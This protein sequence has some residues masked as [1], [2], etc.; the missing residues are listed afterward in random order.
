[1]SEQS[2]ARSSNDAAKAFYG[3]SEAAFAE[4]I[5]QLGAVDP[6]LI[7]AFERTRE[8]F[9]KNTSRFQ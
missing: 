6:R 2:M 9:L 3:Q 7:K 8:T 1:M 4:H 5:K